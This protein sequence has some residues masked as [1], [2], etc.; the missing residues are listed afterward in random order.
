MKR[1]QQTTESFPPGHQPR[2]PGV[3]F[4]S[5]WVIAVLLQ[6]DLHAAVFQA[7]VASVKITPPMP[8]WLAGYANRT[9]PAST[10][11]SDLWA[12]ALALDDGRGGRVVFVTVDLIG[13]SREIC[14][15]VA[16]RSEKL[17]K[18]KRSQLLLNSSHTHWGP[19]VWSNLRAMF[20]FEPGEKQRVI[21]YSEKLTDDL[22]ALVS[23]ALN[24]LSPAKLSSGHG[25]AGFAMNRR[26][27]TPNGFVLGENPDGP[28]DQD[29]PV[30]KITTPDGQLRAVLFGYACH[31]TTSSTKVQVDADFAG[32]AQRSLEAG[33]PGATALFMLLCAGDQNPSP[34]GSEELAEQH[35]QSLA[36]AVDKVL[37]G[38]MKPV[39]GPVHTAFQTTQLDF[40]THTREQFEQEAKEATNASRKRRAKFVLEAYEKKQ[41]PRRIPYPV[42]AVRFADGLTFLAL[43]GEVV[44]DYSLRAKNEFAGEDLVVAGYC[45]EVMCYIPS[46][47]VLREGGYEPVDSMA[48][49]GRPGPFAETVEE[50]IFRSV[51]QVMKQVG[52]KPASLQR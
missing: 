22:A 35:G 34:R 33:H 49:Y 21:H 50:K 41:P 17:H 43:G 39:S 4:F 42:Q 37:A 52:A 40:A 31:N 3:C 13:L 1:H 44:V 45:N 27:P 7:G 2:L 51:R 30:L 16:A 9:N 12:K 20:D 10:V 19:V 28:V 46:L 5:L 11:R 6:S 47:R 23:A 36:A 48:P 26:K 24:N 32:A 15:E 8:F 14:D 25:S 18:L 29:V 38:E